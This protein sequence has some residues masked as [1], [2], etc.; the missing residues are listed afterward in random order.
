MR[1]HDMNKTLQL[2]ALQMDR[3]VWSQDSVSSMKSF[4]TSSPQS[5][6]A[7]VMLSEFGSAEGNAFGPRPEWQER[8]NHRANEVLNVWISWLN[9]TNSTKTG[10]GWAQPIFINIRNVVNTSGTL[11]GVNSGNIA[12]DE[13]PEMHRRNLDN[14]FLTNQTCTMK[15]SGQ[16]QTVP[17]NWCWQVSSF[18]ACSIHGLGELHG[19]LSIHVLQEFFQFLL[20]QL[21]LR[22]TWKDCWG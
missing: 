21:A 16:F 1:Q 13:D 3:W 20:F 5:Q 11:A 2:E 6:I 4:A 19:S 14:R 18:S 12:N 9:S 17:V 8:H 10:V 7:R 22:Q 15:F